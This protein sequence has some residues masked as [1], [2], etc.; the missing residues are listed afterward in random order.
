MRHEILYRPSYSLLVVSLEAGE[1]LRAEPGGMVSMSPSIEVST[2]MGGGLFGGLKRAILGGESFFMNTFRAT[3][4]GEVSFAPSLSGD[5]IH[6][7]LRGQDIL[8]QSGSFLASAAS[9]AVDTTW[10][11]ARGF[12]AGEG[13][14]LLRLSGSGDLWVSSYGAIHEKTLQPGERYIVDTGHI[15]AF[16]ASC[17]YGVRRIG[18]LKTTIFGGEGL[19]A[20]FTGPGR[21]WLQSR[22]PGAFLDWLLPRLP[23]PS[24]G[25]SRWSSE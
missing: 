3:A 5:V 4:P 8:A 7:P 14:F 2:G 21:L 25:G 6:M 1:E 9:V 20:D 17:T 10:G 15:V 22:S 19:V 13:L 24:S 16:D 11:G 23:K 18:G 12:F